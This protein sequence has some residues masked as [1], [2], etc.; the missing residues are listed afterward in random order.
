MS[1][2]EKTAV[3]G[4]VGAIVA[5]ASLWISSCVWTRGSVEADPDDAVA[6]AP[7]EAAV[8]PRLLFSRPVQRADVLPGAKPPESAARGDTASSDA[9]KDAGKQAERAGGHV[10]M[11]VRLISLSE[12]SFE[13]ARVFLGLGNEGETEGGAK[14]DLL[15]EIGAAVVLKAEHAKNLLQMASSDP[16]LSAGESSSNLALAS[17]Q[18]GRIA[19]FGGPSMELRC[20]P[21]VSPD[22]KSLRI[23]LSYGRR[24]DAAS[25][26]SV[27]EN[28]PDGSA[29]LVAVGEEVRETRVEVTTPILAHIP[30]VNRYFREVGILRERS[31]K[32]LMLT[33]QVVAQ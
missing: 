21:T 7:D 29:L 5:A 19:D 3:C 16:R 18:E 23:A 1:S 27:S 15:P 33:P 26:T 30:F 4:M 14:A 12:F 24:G 8:P 28:V 17:G 20:R 10:V 6:E 31:L 2:W 25:L 13:E 9:K 22:S 11:E 32:V